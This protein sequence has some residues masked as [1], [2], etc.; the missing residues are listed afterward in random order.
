M[1]HVFDNPDHW[2]CRI[3]LTNPSPIQTKKHLAPPYP[4]HSPKPSNHKDPI[5]PGD[6]FILPASAITSPL[7]PASHKTPA[8]GLE[9]EILIKF[10]QKRIYSFRGG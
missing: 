7:P 4:I 6:A 5:V 10:Y 3:H 9:D 1:T 8:S 2:Q